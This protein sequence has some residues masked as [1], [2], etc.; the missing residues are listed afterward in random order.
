MDVVPLDVGEYSDVG[1]VRERNED[2]CGT[3]MEPHPAGRLFVVA[4]GVGGEYFGDEA[5]QMAVKRIGELFYAY[6]ESYPDQSLEECLRDM[7][8]QV[9]HE[10]YDVAEYRG[11]TGHMGTTLVVAV[12]Q[13]RLLTVAW[14]GDSRAYVVN[15][16]RQRIRQITTDH[17]RVEEMVQHGELSPEEALS[18]PRRSELSRSMGG[19]PHVT[20]DIVS[21]ELEDGDLAILCSDGLTRYL[22]ETEILHYALNAPASQQ[23]A[24]AMVSQA[25][26]SGGKDNITCVVVHMGDR[27]ESDTILGPGESKAAVAQPEA[28]LARRVLKSNQIVFGVVMLLGLLTVV[29]IVIMLGPGGDDTAQANGDD[30]TQVSGLLETNTP[31]GS[32]PTATL[33]TPTATPTNT[34][35]PSQTP[36]P[37]P[38]STRQ[39]DTATPLPSNVYPVDIDTVLYTT[40]NANVRKVADSSAEISYTLPVDTRVV[41]KPSTTSANNVHHYNE[42][43]HVQPDTSQGSGWVHES[44]LSPTR[45]EPAE[46]NTSPS[47]ANWSNG[48]TV[49]VS[50]TSPTNLMLRRDPTDQGSGFGGTLQRGE[51]LIIAEPEPRVGDDGGWWWEVNR[52]ADTGWM[53]QNYLTTSDR[54]EETGG[55]PTSDP[56]APVA[57]DS[58]GDGV[59]DGRDDC[60][61]WGDNGF[62]VWD[63]GCPKDDPNPPTAES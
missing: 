39:P 18:H 37:L 6:A 51:S 58:D 40:T 62:G 5:S 24:E 17:S 30:P 53:A 50:S 34:L 47:W 15:R 22:G 61:N 11:V 26:Q 45:P 52:G 32:E 9:N 1:Q 41:V 19:N 13:G 7:V 2:S 33:I 8:I 44:H 63:N 60:P 36:T 38:T 27:T 23:A 49:W 16:Q 20:P 59:P 56:Q 35:P 25:N 28:N 43:Y 14:V 48:M 4:D 3:F 12:L 29:L 10:I 57:T 42:Y 21:G 55:Q 46:D 54:A 31:S